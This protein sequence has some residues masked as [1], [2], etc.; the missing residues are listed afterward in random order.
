MDESPTKR[1]SGEAASPAP[2]A[3]P[4]EGPAADGQRAPL[5][6][7][8]G[9]GRKRELRAAI[10]ELKREVETQT[11]ARDAL[12][13]EAGLTVEQA[14]ELNDE[15]I[16]RLHRY[17]DIKDAGQILFGKLAELKGKTVK[18]M[19]AEYGVDLRD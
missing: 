7:S 6:A 9:S 19:Y 2:L 12:L 18:D 10:D 17:N 15:L 16:G 5:I 1:K 4:A 13:G 11:Q 8:P 14:R 3:L